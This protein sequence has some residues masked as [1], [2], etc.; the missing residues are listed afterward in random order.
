MPFYLNSQKF[1]ET[2]YKTKPIK[3]KYIINCEYN[4]FFF[5]IDFANGYKEVNKRNNIV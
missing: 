1:L 5:I 3:G 2:I 4:I